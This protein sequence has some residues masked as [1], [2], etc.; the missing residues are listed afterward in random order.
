MTRGRSAVPGFVLP[1]ATVAAAIATWQVVV[2]LGLDLPGPAA[3]AGWVIGQLDESSFW[4]AFFDTLRHWALGL[5]IGASVGSAVGVL[6]GIVPLVQRLFQVPIEFLRTIP[7]VVYLPLL[8]LVMGA[9]SQVV[10]L[11]GAVSAFWPMLYQAFYGTHDTDPVAVDTGK[12]FG[13]SAGQRI[14]HIIVPGVLPFLATGLRIASAVSLVVAVTIELI[15]G[16]PGLGAQLQSYQQSGIDNGIYG[17]IFVMG[18]LGVALNAGL[19]NVERRLLRWH[20]AYR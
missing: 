3:V 9:T 16:V 17:I 8:L 15:A 20:S 1:A 11:L 18:L 5:V 13:L 10:I 19:V 12:V 2:A 14:R 7:A 6:L 4:T